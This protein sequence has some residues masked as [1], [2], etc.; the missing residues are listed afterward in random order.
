MP[1]RRQLVLAEAAGQARTCIACCA[2]P[3]SADTSARPGSRP[4]ADNMARVQTAAEPRQP[5]QAQHGAANRPVIRLRRA[6]PKRERRCGW[7]SGALSRPGSW[8]ARDGTASPWWQPQVKHGPHAVSSLHISPPRLFAGLAPTLVLLPNTTSAPAI[9]GLL[10]L[11]RSHPACGA[12]CALHH[13]P[14]L[15]M[16]RVRRGRLVVL[17]RAAP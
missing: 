7:P 8:G 12:F 4:G 15:T 1:L 11:R 6:L 14:V 16:R 2:L 13:T 5:D 17:Y 3:L 9:P 10:L